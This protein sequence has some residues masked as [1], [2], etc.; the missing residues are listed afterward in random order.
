MPKRLANDLL[1]EVLLRVDVGNIIQDTEASDANGCV[2]LKSIVKETGTTSHDTNGVH[3]ELRHALIVVDERLCVLS[4]SFVEIV[5]GILTEDMQEVDAHAPVALMGKMVLGSDVSLQMLGNSGDCFVL[6]L[7]A[8]H[9][10]VVVK[11]VGNEEEGLVRA[12]N[13]PPMLRATLGGSDVA[14]HGWKSGR[15]PSFIMGFT[16]C[17]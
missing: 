12:D 15:L 17:N 8:D 4:A 14:I 3:A 6:V 9:L 2:R 11:H 7:F 10:V 1:W 13:V 5:L 16:R